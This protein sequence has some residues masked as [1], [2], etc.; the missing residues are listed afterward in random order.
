MPKFKVSVECHTPGRDE[1][2]WLKLEADDEG[3]APTL[4]DLLENGA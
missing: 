4:F 2:H 3:D 1:I